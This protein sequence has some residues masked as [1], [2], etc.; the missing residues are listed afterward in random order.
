MGY[1]VFFRVV[2]IYELVDNGWGL[3]VNLGPPSYGVNDVKGVEVDYEFGASWV[4]GFKGK[5]GWLI[6]EVVSGWWC[7]WVSVFVGFGQLCRM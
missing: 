7:V 2:W 1:W 3:N 4:L 5:L 6:N